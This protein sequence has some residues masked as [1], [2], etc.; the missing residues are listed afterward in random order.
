MINDFKF[1]RRIRTQQNKS[2]DE[3]FESYRII[4]DFKKII[5]YGILVALPLTYLIIPAYITLFPN[6]IPS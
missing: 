2:C 4:R 3:I 6:G 1:Y 5:P